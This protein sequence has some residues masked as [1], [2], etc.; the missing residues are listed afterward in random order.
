MNNKLTEIPIKE[1]LIN[2]YTNKVIGPNNNKNK[3]KVSL[4]IIST[5]FVYLLLYVQLVYYQTLQH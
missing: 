4:F 2:E 3:G 5:Y 1:K